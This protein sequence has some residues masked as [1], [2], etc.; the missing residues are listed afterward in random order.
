MALQERILT[1]SDGTRIWAES[2]GNTSKPTIVFV[3]G[4]SCTSLG[5]DRQFADPELQ[6]EFHL[7]RYEMR[8][9]GRSGKP[10]DEAAYGSRKIAEDFRVVCEAFGV[11]KPF[12]AGWSLG[13]AIVVDVVTAYG[14]NYLSGVI[15]IGGSIVALHYHGPCRHPHITEVFPTTVSFT[16]DDLSEGAERFVDSCFA[17]TLTYEERLSFMGGFIMQPRSARFWSIKRTQ[18]HTVWEREARPLPV[19]IVQGTED[20]HCLYETMTSIARRVYDDVEVKIMPGIGH[21]PH[22][23][24]TVETNR[25]IVDWVKKAVEKKSVVRI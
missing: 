8:G 21:T 14:V 10:L 23:E 11:V 7:V 6:R 13:G 12:L 1:S 18:D 25:I 16:S 15:Y 3:H 19:L 22:Y 24:N 5:W 9:H 17:K 4:L 20:L 2:N